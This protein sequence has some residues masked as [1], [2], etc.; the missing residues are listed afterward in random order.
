MMTHL[1]VVVIAPCYI[2]SQVIITIRRRLLAPSTRKGG[3]TLVT[4]G[5]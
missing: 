1:D 3:F 2:L 5:S 4:L